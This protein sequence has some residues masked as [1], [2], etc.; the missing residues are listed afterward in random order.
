MSDNKKVWDIAVRVFHW[1][2]VL[3]FTTAYVTGDDADTLHAYAGYI[4]I[5]LLGFRVIWGFIGTATARFRSFLYSPAET[6][7]YARSFVTRKPIH[8]IGHN[9]LGS[10]MVFALLL[11]ISLT[12]WSG[13]KVYAL[14]GKGP[15]AQEVNL[16]IPQAQA[17][18][19]EHEQ[20]SRDKGAHRFW[21]EVHELLANFTL[22]L[23]IVH[24]IGAVLA[25]IVHGEN[26]IKA[27]VTGRRERVD[28][29]SE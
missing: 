18:D 7:R 20:A 15:L 17:D 10:L 13:L 14:E 9:P 16:V 11:F 12:S 29:G 5:G 4:I 23:V 26:L 27:M 24:I 2:L 21:K 25:S 28:V 3:F 22:F 6:M 1:S 8:Y 19:D